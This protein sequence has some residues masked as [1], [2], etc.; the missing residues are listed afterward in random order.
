MDVGLLIRY[1]KLIPGREVPA[2]ELFEETTAYFRKKVEEGTITFFEPFFMATGDF[3]T[4]IGFFVLKGPAPEIF[5]LETEEEY[6][7]L[8]QKGL[9]LV[10]HLRADVLTVGEGI[11][12][13]LE[14]AAKVRAELAL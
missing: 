10:E 14:R 4:E 3:E 6:L 7:H 11:P 8:M 9:M 12:L 1:G 13:Q 2:L 5:K